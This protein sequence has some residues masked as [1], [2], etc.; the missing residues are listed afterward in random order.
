MS[1]GMAGVDAAVLEYLVD[2]CIDRFR[3][4]EIRCEGDEE[5]AE[6]L[7]QALLFLAKIMGWS[8]EELR[9]RAAQRG[10]PSSSAIRWFENKDAERAAKKKRRGRVDRKG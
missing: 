6:N 8:A 2:L 7:Y 10:E 9:C 4:I 1:Y 3:V 5:E